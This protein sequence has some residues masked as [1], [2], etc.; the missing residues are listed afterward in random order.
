M[1]AATVDFETYYDKE[2]SLSKI[3]TEDYVTDPRFEIIL[4]TW[5][6]DDGPITV[7]HGTKEQ[8]RDA[9]LHAGLHQM[10]WIAHNMMFDGLIAA[11]QLGIFP[12]HYFCTLQMAQARLKPYLRSIS[13]ASC[14]KY[15]DLGIQK[16]SYVQNMLGK[17]RADMSAYEFSEYIKYC[18]TDTEGTYRLFR[19]LLPQFPP[20]EFK[21]MDMHTRMYLQPYLQL[22][23]E[24]LAQILAK[25]IANK[26]VLLENLPEGVKKDQLM[27]NPQLAKVLEALGVKVPMKQSPTNPDKMTFAFSKTDPQWKDLEEEY[28]DDPVVSAVMAARTGVKSTLIET[29]SQRL[30]DISKRYTKFRVPLRYYAA[31]P[32]RSGGMESLNAQNFPR[33]KK[34]RGEA[35]DRRQLRFAVTAPKHHSILTADL[36]QIE[37]RVT[38]WLAGCEP[39]LDA[40]RNDRDVYS[41]FASI[42]FRRPITKADELERFLGKTCILGLGYGMGAPKLVT[43]VRRDPL[44]SMKL[45]PPDAYF[46]VETYRNTYQEIPALWALCTDAIKVMAGGGQMRIGPCLASKGK[47]ELPNGMDL[48][49]PNLHYDAVPLDGRKPGYYYDFAGQRRSLFG[50][51]VVENIVQALSRILIW[52]YA[53]QIKKHL[54]LDL[55][56]QAHD[57]LVYVVLSKHVPGYADAVRKIMRVPPSWGP[58]IPIDV[59]TGA[60]LTYGDAK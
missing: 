17:R 47:I 9:M 2:Y 13:L 10:P 34:K 52:W 11:H 48:I 32:G 50:G 7:C 49:Y 25:D 41:E 46:Y 19:Y 28:A 44:M 57:E 15:C 14:L 60:G 54:K 33:I 42:I 24:L 51:K 37:A 31:H 27:S 26:E 5:K 59:E 22:D 4:V 30:L 29:R 3:S 38:A 8:I 39:L 20:Q 53:E 18:G 12:P 45:A 23:S 35:V 40:F 6:V 21:Y 36:K 43:T 55:S 58:D 16:G 1:S 56:L